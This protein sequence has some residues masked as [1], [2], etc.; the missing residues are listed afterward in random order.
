MQHN[1]PCG[2]INVAAGTAGEMD[3][4]GS[5]HLR[6][7]RDV[8]AV[9]WRYSGD[10]RMFS[11][12]QQWISFTSFVETSLYC[13]SIVIVICFC[14]FPQLPVYFHGMHVALL[15]AALT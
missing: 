3:P 5:S 9:T 8:G 1:V 13:S 4:S 10:V 2:R 6:F 15:S 14:F 11:G 12:L 7:K